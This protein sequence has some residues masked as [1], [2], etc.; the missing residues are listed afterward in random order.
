[1]SVQ[2]FC[3]VSNSLHEID[4]K[5]MIDFKKNLEWSCKHLL[6]ASSYHAQLKSTISLKNMVETEVDRTEYEVDLILHNSSN[7]DSTALAPYVA[8][9][10]DVDVNDLEVL[11]NKIRLTL[12]Q[13]KLDALA[14]LDSVNR[15]EEVRPKTWYNDQAR[16]ILQADTMFTLTGYQGA[17]QIV[18]IADTGFDQGVANDTSSLKVHPAF[19]NRV[20][21]LVSL[22]NDGDAKD[23]VGHGTHVCGSVLGSGIYAGPL[24]T[25]LKVQG[26]APS[27]KLMMQSLSK[28]SPTT[29]K[30]ILKSPADMTTLFSVPYD[31][32]IRIH[33]NSWGN[34]WDANIGQLGYESD[35]T[36]IDT[37]I[38]QHQGFV[39]LIA[40]GNDA[41]KDNH[42][43][44]QVGDNSAAKNC[45]TVGATGSTRPNDGQK[46]YS[47]QS[48]LSNLGWAR[49]TGVKD[50]A[51]FSSRG[52][53]K[54]TVNSQGQAVPGRI[55][56]DVVAPGVV[57]MS[58]ASRSVG[59]NDPV[60]TRYGSSKDPDWIF[61][62]GTSMA[63][64]L[65]AGCVA[66]IRQALQE[67]SKQQPSAALIKALLV[68][69]AVNYSSS[70]GL[71]FDYEQGF[72]RVD[73]DSS[74]AMITQSTFIEGGS[75]FETTK[76]DVSGL[77]DSPAS[78]RQWESPGIAIPSGGRSSLAVTFAYPDPPGA[79][80]QNDVNLIV[81]TGGFERH[82]NMG[83]GTDFDHTSMF[84]FSVMNL[85]SQ[86]AR[87]QRW[88]TLSQTMLRKSFGTIY[89]V[90]RPPSSC[91]L[92]AS[93][94]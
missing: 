86:G 76:Y 66:L 3:L 60:R 14:A 43:T 91:R 71:G 48:A 18:C 21:E 50:T 1:M 58:A 72:G 30:W 65:T 15:I 36:R 61:L 57:I 59:A 10:A 38:Y 51:I 67:C 52:P 84:L 6:T 94:S 90:R 5:T 79:L 22:W 37:F 42:G 31:L 9:S 85:I 54:S 27:A 33:N 70:S 83:S 74:I 53:T 19:K 41:E 35:A 8:Q 47:D 20:E 2:I 40:A 92:T 49:P 87:H 17:G 93:R 55:K 81:R 69:G 68:N 28:Y 12:Q 82:G 45:I 89:L 7:V 56:P 4:F 73:V 44:S 26:T 11:P 16:G 62:S 34:V 77:S 46:F 25:E 24:G 13:D 80:L 78:A 75:K 63:T 39:V 64:P 32:G 23:P 88:L 29:K